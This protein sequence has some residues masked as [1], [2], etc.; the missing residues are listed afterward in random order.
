MENINAELQRNISKSILV[1]LRN[2]SEVRGRLVGY[3]QHMN[4]ILDDAEEIDGKENIKRGLMFIRGD[5][6]VFISTL[7]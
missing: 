4:L 6:I 3:D 2:N 1:K 7:G 5:T